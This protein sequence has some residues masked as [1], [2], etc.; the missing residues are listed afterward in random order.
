VAA[1]YARIEA[2]HPGR[3]IVGLGGAHGSKPLQT[4]TS[5]PVRPAS[6]RPACPGW[7]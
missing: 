4:L 3:F 1:W 5:Y 7:E 6:D 2:T